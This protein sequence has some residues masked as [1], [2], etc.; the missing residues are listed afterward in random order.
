MTCKNCGGTIDGKFCRH[1]GQ[2]SKVG[3]IDWPSFI[4]DLSESV[5]QVD[6]GFFYSFRALFVRPGN[7][8]QEYISGKRKSHFKPIAYVLILS[9]VYFLITQVTNQNTWIDELITGWMIGT[10]GQESE[11]EIPALARWFAKNYAYTT[12]LLLPVFSFASYLSFFKYGKN[13]LEH[14]VI[15]SYITGQKAIFYSLFALVGFFT[16]NDLF[17]ALSLLASIAYTFWVFWQFFSE[18][19]RPTNLLRSLM[20]YVLYWIFSTV[21]LFVLVGFSEM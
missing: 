8:I 1:C 9:T 12:L 15:N 13:Y 14:I 21:L 18:G 20:I 11:A 16:E 10:S 3:R 7:S 5:F 19:R 4:N 6:R 2:H 17:A